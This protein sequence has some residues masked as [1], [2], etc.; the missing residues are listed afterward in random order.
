MTGRTPALVT[1][2]PA[3]LA[4]VDR[5]IVVEGGKI[6]ADGPRDEILTKASRSAHVASAVA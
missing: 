4:L 5:I 2:R 1:H 6:V 3:L